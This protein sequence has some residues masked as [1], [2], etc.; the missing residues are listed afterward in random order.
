VSSG[1]EDAR[2]IE[3]CHRLRIKSVVLSGAIR[4]RPPDLERHVRFDGAEAN[5]C[6]FSHLDF[7]SY[8]ASD[9]TFRDCSFESS[10][11]VYAD[12]GQRGVIYEQCIFRHADLRG[13]AVGD[14][15]FRQCDFTA[16][17]ITGWMAFCA[18]FIECRFA[19]R[20]VD[21]VFSASPGVWTCLSGRI[22]HD[23]RG[24]DFSDAELVDTMFVGGI[25]LD[26]Q[27]W[28]SNDDYVRIRGAADRIKQAL[29]AVAQ[30]PE[31][32]RTSARVSLEMLASFAEDQNE[33]IV[34]RVDV[35]GDLGGTAEE[36]WSLLAG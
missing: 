11:F 22:H 17:R 33:L 24:N 29:R 32:S 30:W 5:G 26:Q 7:V 21:S 1:G 28:P 34:R 3:S 12:L 9:S 16:A 35:D 2:A 10:R 36:F 19:T 31:P 27:R 8:A 6:D 15:T 14:A 4:Q 23:F 18:Q 25:D 13:I 20:I